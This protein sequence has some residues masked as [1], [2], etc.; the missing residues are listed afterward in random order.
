MA[1]QSELLPGE[2]VIWAGKPELGIVFH[3]ED[4]LLIPFSLLWG[5]FAIFWE[6]SVIGLGHT[7]AWSFFSLWGIAFVLIGQ[8]FIWGR[9]VYMAWL[10]KR[11]N[12]AVTNRRILVAQDGW[13]RQVASTYIDSLPTLTKD[14]GARGIGTLHFAEA[15]P[16]WSKR[17]GWGAWNGL[18][19]GGTPHIRGYS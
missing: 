16:V 3:K 15:Q 8:Y 11:T 6:A 5:G 13:K 4:G 12:Y 17:R 9:F 1:V 2:S 18:S 19:V 10:K 14:S 7:K